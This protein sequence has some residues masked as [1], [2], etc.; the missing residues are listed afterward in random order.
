MT[1]AEIEANVASDPDAFI[2]GEAWFA[3]ARLVVPERKQQL[4]LRLDTGIIAHFR[5]LG[6]R[7][8]TRINAVLKRYVEAQRPK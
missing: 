1:D 7:W 5:A 2:L 8:Q 4:T 3:Q 6:P